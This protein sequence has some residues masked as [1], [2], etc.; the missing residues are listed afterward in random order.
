MHVRNLGR[1]MGQRA[2]LALPL[3]FLALLVTTPALAQEGGNRA[4]LVVVHADG[5]VVTRCVVFDELTLSG[6][7]LLQRSDLAFTTSVG[8]LGATVC[9][10]NGEGCPASDCFCQCKQAPCAY[11][12][13]Y[14]RNADGSWAYATIGAAMRQLGN[15]DVDAWMWGDGSTVPPQVSFE[16]ICAPDEPVD[17]VSET[18]PPTIASTVT[19]PPTAP[20]I[21][22]PTATIAP[23]QETVQTTTPTPTVT[24][25]STLRADERTATSEPSA[26]LEAT[27]TATPTL[28][29]TLMMTVT[30]SPAAAADTGVP[31]A[32]PTALSQVPVNA[33]PASPERGPGGGYLAFGI[34][35][36]VLTGAFLLVRHKRRGA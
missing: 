34:I 27:S 36:G 13:Y 23:T 29:P 35:L 7:T 8:P 32:T 11:W 18:V 12:N 25:S 21:L 19:V 2:R 17:P 5:R 4:G 15:G 33:E 1:L 10:L 26:V 6:V 14:H 9:S 24:P 31:S 30:A 28:S 20:A 22:T 3:L 16:A